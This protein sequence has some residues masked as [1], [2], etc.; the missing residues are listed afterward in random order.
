MFQKKNYDN[1]QKKVQKNIEHQYNIIMGQLNQCVVKKEENMEKLYSLFDDGD[2]DDIMNDNTQDDIYDNLAIGSFIDT[3]S[4][5][6]DTTTYFKSVP[7]MNTLDEVSLY[8]INLVKS[9]VENDNESLIPIW[10]LYKMKKGKAIKNKPQTM[11]TFVV[12]TVNSLLNK[13]SGLRPLIG[14]KLCLKDNDSSGHL[15]LASVISKSITKY[16]NDMKIIMSRVFERSDPKASIKKKS[17]KLTYHIPSGVGGIKKK[18]S[19]V[20]QSKITNFSNKTRGLNVKKYIMCAITEDNKLYTCHN[21]MTS[22]EYWD[23]VNHI[24]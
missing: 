4:S 22:Q 11:Y 8:A 3:D 13:N 5:A 14:Q 19:N 6:M 15:K 10:V 18:K 21:D 17:K 20:F 9:I 7:V 16:K 24:K 23:I 12:S 1:I 2:D